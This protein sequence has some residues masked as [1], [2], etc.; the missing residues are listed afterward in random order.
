MHILFVAHAS[1]IQGGANR[2]LLSII[3]N[4]KDNKNFTVTVLLPEKVG[5][6]NDMLDEM[7]VEWIS[8]KYHSLVTK[9]VK[10]LSMILR[11]SKLLG[12]FMLDLNSSWKLSRVLRGKKVDLIYTNTRV[13][14]VGAFAAKLLGVPHIW[15]I[16]EFIEE[17]DLRT[18]PFTLNII[19]NLSTEIIVIS[20]AIRNSIIRKVKDDKI[21]LV[22]NGLPKQK[23]N[24]FRENQKDVFNMLITGTIIP[25][26]GQIEAV[27]VL[28]IL[29]ERGYKNL[30][31]H[32]VGNSPERNQNTGYIGDIK[33]FVKGNEIEDNIIF[34]GE[35]D[36][37]SKL[38]EEMDIE[39]MCSKSEAFGRVTVEGMQ[40]RLVVIG[41]RGGATPE[42]IKDG[43]NG[44]L[45]DTGNIHQLADKIEQVYNDREFKEDLS[46]NAYDFSK[47]NF[48]EEG[49]IRGITKILYK[50]QKNSN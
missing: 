19:N 28:K 16:R 7:E 20:N 39:L 38:R 37:V 6:M 41:A 23:I 27:K 46:R 15:H 50:I 33:E 29:K 12:N 1:N 43:I 14:Y 22:Y 11:K 48:T 47:N 44:L 30:K 49:Y 32:I 21:N 35:I 26:K 2:S 5:T 45:Y 17:N 10:S 31:L 34:H 4:L 8:L 9:K 36:N 24:K 3:K 13:I 40:S 18:V 42:I 25:A